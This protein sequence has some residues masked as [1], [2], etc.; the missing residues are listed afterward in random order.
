MSKV[1]LDALRIEQAEVAE[2]PRPPLGPRLLLGALVLLVLGVALSFLMPLLRPARE[3][4]T[5]RV[6]AASQ[7]GSV[8]RVGVAEAAG[9]IEPEPFP[10]HVRPLV[11]GVVSELLVLEGTVVKKG[12]TVI[13]RLESAELLARRDRAAATLKLREA[14]V[15]RA[16]ADHVVAKSLLE[17][18]GQPRLALAEARQALVRHDKGIERLERDLDAAVADR[19]AK[20][21]EA[22]G[23]ERLLAAGGTY[24]V[25][26]ATA[27]ANL[28][29]AQARLKS[30]ETDLERVRAE[31]ADVVERRR[32]A[33]ELVDDPRGLQG[34][35]D[36]MAAEL[37]KTKA[38]RD[39]AQTELD[40]AEREL[41]WCEVKSPIDGVVMKLKVA[42]GETV[43][44]MS[45]EIVDL[46]QPEKLQ[47][48]IDVPLASV[49]E[50]APSARRWT[51]RTRGACR[52]K[53]TKGVV[54]PHPARVGP[55]QEHHCR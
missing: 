18:K 37:L 5:A 11:V 41:A 54:A 46:Y 19:D 1:D 52:N 17:Q 36:R 45:G 23:Q 38:Q 29:A 40:I 6:R 16:E 13:A 35:L 12:E 33:Q 8:G 55:A 49:G 48:R 39:A 20:K 27:R 42:P 9:W 31:R 43:G 22:E 30:V 24:P 50:H 32:I 4:Q 51:M 44:P 2:A 47:A 14:E 3:V 25:A 15:A 53:A 7:T 34:E 28:R 21:S 26:L 10:I